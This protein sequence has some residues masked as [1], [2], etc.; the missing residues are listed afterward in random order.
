[1]HVLNSCIIVGLFIIVFLITHRQGNPLTPM[2]RIHHQFPPA[3]QSRPSLD[4][5][6]ISRQNL[7]FR[8][9]PPSITGDFKHC[10]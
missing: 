5:G 7:V 1:M 2:R 10:N 9:F 3:F 6:P 4:H 8:F